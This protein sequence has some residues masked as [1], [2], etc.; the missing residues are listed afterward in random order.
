VPPSDRKTIFDEIT[1]LQQK[2]NF[3]PAGLYDRVQVDASKL[4]LHSN[5]SKAE[6]AN[7]IDTSMREAVER[8]S[9]GNYNVYHGK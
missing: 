5:I 3:P 1:H 9:V 4:K 2:Q 7:Y 6:K 8:P